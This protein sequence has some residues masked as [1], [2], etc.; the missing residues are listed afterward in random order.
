IG[1]P[2]VVIDKRQILAFGLQKSSFSSVSDTQVRLVDYAEGNRASL[3]A[4]AR[5]L[6]GIV[7][8]GVV[9]H[10]NFP[11]NSRWNLRFEMQK[12]GWE[13]NRPVVRTDYYGD[14]IGRHTNALPESSRRLPFS[15]GHLQRALQTSRLRAA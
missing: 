10:Q 5:H 14:A 15:L 3:P 9:N 1:Y 6:R 13:A 12:G 4:G 11:W 2:V 8:G 7:G